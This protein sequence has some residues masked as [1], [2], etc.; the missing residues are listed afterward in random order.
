MIAF[1]WSCAPE[2]HTIQS[3]STFLRGLTE[4][5]VT[6]KVLASRKRGKK[7]ANRSKNEHYPYN[8][9]SNPSGNHNCGLALTRQTRYQLPTK[10][11]IRLASAFFIVGYSIISQEIVKI[12]SE[13]DR[14]EKIL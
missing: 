10:L 7:K 6:A 11:T 1:F 9:K 3:G 4:G 8:I 13:G 14:L 12:K 2:V 5:T